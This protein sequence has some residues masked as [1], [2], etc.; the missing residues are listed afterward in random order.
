MLDIHSKL[1]HMSSTNWTTCGQDLAKIGANRIEDMNL[2]F[3]TLQ[4]EYKEL[5]IILAQ[6]EFKAS[7]RR[8]HAG[9]MRVVKQGI[10]RLEKV[11]KTIRFILVVSGGDAIR[12]LISNGAGSD[13]YTAKA[14]AH[15]RQSKGWK[16]LV[17]YKS[18]YMLLVV[19]YV[20]EIVGLRVADK[21][22]NKYQFGRKLQYKSARYTFRI[23]K[24]H[25]IDATRKG[26]IARFV[27]HSC[28]PNCV[29]KVISMRSEKK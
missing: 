21:R 29:A 5:E 19:E 2:E 24:E 7:F 17:V 28:L 11:M 23:D 14:Y 6:N 27:N 20:G 25:I 4:T 10:R 8:K 15:Y 3:D 13:S 16:H 26:G 12:T 18:A 9:R 22:E 1:G